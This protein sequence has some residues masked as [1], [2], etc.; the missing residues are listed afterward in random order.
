MTEIALILGLIPSVKSQ[1][2]LACVKIG[3]NFRGEGCADLR[4]RLTMPSRLAL[5]AS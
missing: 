4:L 3:M 5:A 1:G 2:A